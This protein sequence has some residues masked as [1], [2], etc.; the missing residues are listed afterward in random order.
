MAAV[1]L[2]IWTLIEKY[3]LPMLNQAIAKVIELFGVSEEDAQAFVANSILVGFEEV[4]I[5]AATLR[6]KLPI[7]VA[8]RLGFTS[9]GFTK[10]PYSKAGE[11][12]LPK[13]AGVPKAQAVATAE[14]VS[15]IA[16]VV[17]VKRGSSLAVVGSVYK[18]VLSFVGVSS[19]VVMTIGNFIDFANWQGAYQK[20]F[21]KFFT[22]LG[23]PPDSPM[24]SAKSVSADT[25]KK[26]YTIVEE[27]K[28]ESIAFPWDDTTKPY[29]RSNLS[30]AVDH[31]SANLAAQGVDTTYKNVW[32]LLLPCIKLKQPAGT[33]T[34]T[35]QVAGSSVATQQVAQVRVISGVVSQG[36]IGSTATF[37]PRP[38]DLIENAAELTQAAH[39]NIAPFIAAIGS[40]MSYEIKLVSSVKTA[41][42]FTQRGTVQKVVS[43]YNKDGSPKYRTVVNRFAVAEISIKT[44]RGTQS[45]I[46][47]IVLGPVDSARFQAA[48]VDIQAVNISVQQNIVA[49]ASV[50]TPTVAPATSVSTSAVTPVT[51]AQ[52]QPTTQ[53]GDATWKIYRY[54]TNGI[55]SFQMLPGTNTPWGATVADLGEA[56][57]WFSANPE[58]YKVQ[59]QNPSFDTVLAGGVVSSGL[60]WGKDPL[61]GEMG[62]GYWNA[63]VTQPVVAQATTL[64]DYYKAHGQALPSVEER[65]KTYAELGLGQ[66]AYYTGTAEQNTK[67]LAAL[68]GKR[69]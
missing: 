38:D 29:S 40:Q 9:K 32:G 41:S 50:T 36:V 12:K 24:P 44:D 64:F 60:S 14:E 57:A 49:P 28:P 53:S 39:N 30:D 4:G 51:Q 34:T 19:L 69:L 27:L 22:A 5:F 13:I 61:S 48:N 42:G 25:W 35:Q 16:E 68:Q 6:T 37:T 65:S 59:Q 52:P 47:T 33:I 66:A 10:R 7:T 11:A 45:K 8:E 58:A 20:T 1:Q 18:A 31:F 56:R 17:A 62:W 15:K 21:E 55:P 26:I 2:G 3:G 63:Q 54:N 23:F 46:K 43:G 67:L